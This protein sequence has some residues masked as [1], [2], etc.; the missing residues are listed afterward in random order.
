MPTSVTRVDSVAALSNTNAWAIGATQILHWNGSTWSIFP[1]HF[2][3]GYTVLFS[4]ISA[5]SAS[6][7]WV[8]GGDLGPIGTG[9]FFAHFNGSSWQLLDNSSDAQF[10]NEG[11]TSIAAH[12]SN[13][14]LAVAFNVGDGKPAI[15][16]WNGSSWI[17]VN[18]PALPNP[19]RGKTANAQFNTVTFTPSSD[20]WIGGY[21]SIST[22]SMTTTRTLIEQCMEC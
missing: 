8:T 4:S 16:Q 6:D 18:P 11:F 15:D 20:A 17:P 22:Q 19:G 2:T 14:A 10:Y 3:Q 12:S 1:I 7:I 21:E 5:A 9:S 13:D